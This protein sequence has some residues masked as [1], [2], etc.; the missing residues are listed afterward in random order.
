MPTKV[1]LPP[2]TS[3]GVPVTKRR[4][5]T[6]LVYTAALADLET[7]RAYYRRILPFYEREVSARGDLSFWE[8]LAREWRPKLVL[9]IGCGNGRVA[10]ALSRTAPAVGVDISF[11]LLRR[12]RKAPRAPRAHFLAADFREMAFGRRFDLIVAPS[13]PLSHLTDVSERRRAL[14][15]VARA[16]APGG[17]F[18][19]E[20]LVRKGG[21]PIRSERRLSDRRGELSVREDWTPAGERGLWLATFTYRRSRRDGGVAVTRAS[22]P[23]RSWEP[24]RIRKFFFSCGL[25]VEEIW[26]GVSRRP[27][28]PGSRR[29]IVVARRRSP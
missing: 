2:V 3:A 19:L 5:A 15:A 14:R 9:E 22:F 7:I 6:A 25:A 24:T 18:V 21:K 28:R 29:L 8:G 20:A 4:R 10:R 23:A 17:R 12:A 13:D 26:G 27:Y 11:E 1:P 16:L